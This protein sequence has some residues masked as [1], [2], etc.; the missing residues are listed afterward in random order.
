MRFSRTRET[1]V[2]RRVRLGGRVPGAGDQSGFGVMGVLETRPPSTI[3]HQGLDSLHVSACHPERSEGS[4]R[5]TQRP[6]SF[7]ALRM[8]STGSCDVCAR[9]AFLDALSCLADPTKITINKY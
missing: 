3:A 7:A 5:L 1:L 4:C 8:T 2:S 9:S 6:R